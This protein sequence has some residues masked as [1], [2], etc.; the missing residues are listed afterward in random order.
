M[1]TSITLLTLDYRGAGSGV[2]GAAK[3][4]VRDA[5]GPVQR[6]S[7]RV[8]SPVGSFFG[9]MIHYGD[10]QTENERLRQ[11][12]AGLRGDVYRADDADRERRALLDQ[13]DL[14]TPEDIPRVDARVVST[15]PSNFAYTVEIDKG[16][17]SG[18][19]HGMPVVTGA[20]LV[21]RIADVSRTRAV[22]QLVTDKKFSVGVRLA[23]SGD[24]GV[25]NGTG[26]QS[27]LSVD[28]IDPSTEVPEGRDRGDQR[29]PAEP[30]PS[31][32]SGRES[33]QERHAAQRA[34]TR[35][36]RSAAGRPRAAHI[37]HRAAV[38]APMND[39]RIRLGLV[40]G[41]T[42]IVHLTLLSHVRVAGVR[43]DSLL[44]LAILTGLS[45][46]SER[47]AVVGFAAGLLGD[48]FVQ[49]PLGLGALTYCLVGFVVGSLQS[50]I[51]RAAW[52]IPVATAFV[53]SAAGM[54]LYALLGATVGQASFV[55]PRLAVIAVLVGVMNGALAPAGTRVVEWALRPATSARS[56]AT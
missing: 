18:I 44:L 8:F 11:E 12:I 48:L 53:A 15:S 35:R 49:T 50:G 21:G 45:S 34:P 7:D 32:L 41:F 33:H 28:L 5:F 22:V 51:L 36:H 43:P 9:G 13:L 56:Y 55:S 25:A 4:G 19:T 37:R 52:W 31:R 23:T 17:S 40:L 2:I 27:S 3:D 1:L 16:T 39:L 30:V 42:L 29:P 46:G 20:G 47:G 54:V 6:T 10:L 14:P 38:V 24:V 26:S